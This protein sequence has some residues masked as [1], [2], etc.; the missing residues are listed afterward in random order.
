VFVLVSG[1][2]QHDIDVANGE[3]NDAPSVTEGDDQFPEIPRRFAAAAGVRR[4][5]EYAQTALHRFAKPE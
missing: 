5:R 1:G 2:E 3:Q 4:E